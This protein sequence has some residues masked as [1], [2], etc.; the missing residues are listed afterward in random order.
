MSISQIKTSQ[1][2]SIQAE[3][4]A[5]QLP[6]LTLKWRQ[7]QLL[8]GFEQVKQ[9]YLPAVKNEQWL[10]ECLKHS[11]VKLTRIAPTVGK[12]NLILWAEACEK[13]NK[14]IFLRLPASQKLSTK[15]HSIIW[16]LINRSIAALLLIIFSPV[17]LGL[18]LVRRFQSPQTPVFSKQWCVGKRGKLFRLFKFYPMLDISQTNLSVEDKDYAKTLYLARWMRKY[19][20]DYL[21]QLF[22]VL[23][24]E[25]NLIAPCPLT[26]DD[27]AL[28]NLNQQH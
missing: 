6:Q 17:L 27:I 16:E 11:P 5:K 26:L 24:G 3:Q 7:K 19:N 9:P 28:P 14:A 12:A 22:N 25:I 2:Y 15:Q 8:V 4:T 1:N 23:Q 10:I 13:A 21:P 20:L 18:I